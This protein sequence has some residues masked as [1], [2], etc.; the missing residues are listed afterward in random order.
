MDSPEN[1]PQHRQTPLESSGKV[2]AWSNGWIW[3]YAQ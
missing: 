2:S 1:V 3:S